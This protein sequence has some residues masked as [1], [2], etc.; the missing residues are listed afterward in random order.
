M[1][2]GSLLSGESMMKSTTGTRVPSSV[3]FSTVET[4]IAPVMVYRIQFRIQLQKADF[5]V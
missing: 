1:L 2:Q 3:F 4:K 5:F